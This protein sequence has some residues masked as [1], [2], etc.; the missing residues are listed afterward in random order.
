MAVLYS[1]I[2]KVVSQCILLF[3]IYCY[4]KLVSKM[5]LGCLKSTTIAIKRLLKK[6]FHGENS[7]PARGL[8]FILFRWDKVN[9]TMAIFDKI[10]WWWNESF[11]T[12][13]CQHIT[14]ALLLCNSTKPVVER[15]RTQLNGFFIFQTPITKTKICFGIWG[16]DLTTPFYV[17]KRATPFVITRARGVRASR[18]AR[19][20]SRGSLLCGTPSISV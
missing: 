20:C 12:V 1:E 10:E 18:I 9:W 13:C 5:N 17:E 14:S 15:R 2:E 6:K 8:A 3:R 4:H 19:G 7:G 16:V 11:D